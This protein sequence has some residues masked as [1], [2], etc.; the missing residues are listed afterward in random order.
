MTSL[1]HIDA[2]P[3]HSLVDTVTR[4]ATQSFH[5][6]APWLLLSLLASVP[7]GCL[8]MQQVYCYASS[9]LERYATVMGYTLGTA[10]KATGKSRTSILRA[11]ERGKISAEKNVHGEWNIDPSEL[12]RVYP[13]KQTGNGEDNSTDA[14]AVNSDLL[15]ENRELTARLEAADQRTKDALDQVNDLRL[16]LDQSEDER[17][18]TQAQLTA[19]LTDQRGE[20]P[21][22]RWWPF[23]R[24]RSAG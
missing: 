8:A 17:R 10:A 13:P 21:R 4:S 1:Y 20:R 24:I 9:R 7:E 12:H 23:G 3:T 16:R 15:I 18:R 14:T 6:P 2:I 11:I 22:H 5:S 19:L